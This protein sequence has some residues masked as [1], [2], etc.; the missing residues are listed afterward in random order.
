MVENK[1]GGLPVVRGDQQKV[2]GIISET[3][4]FKLFLNMVKSTDHEL[5][6]SPFLMTNLEQ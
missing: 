3:D 1:M 4:N 2:V 5:H 6:V